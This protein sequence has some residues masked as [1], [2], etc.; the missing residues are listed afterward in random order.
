MAYR[1]EFEAQALEDF[2]RLDGAVKKRIQK[3]IDKISERED[4]RTLGE[5][6]QENLS[7][8]W[9]YRVGDYRLVAE[10]Q[11]EKFIV[12]MLVIDHRRKVYNK[13][14]KRLD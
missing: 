8:Y 13:A 4:P 11:D 12:L 2:S 1:I 6:L 7:T 10:I 3:Y 5:P 9:K 14:S